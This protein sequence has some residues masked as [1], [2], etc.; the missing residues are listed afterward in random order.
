MK[1]LVAYYSRYGNTAHLAN[2]LSDTL[3]KSGKADIVQIEYLNRNPNILKRIFYR[4]LPVF[5][6][7]APVQEDLKGYDRLFVCIPVWGGRP[8][9]PITKYLLLTKNTIGK[10]AICFYVYGFKKSALVCSD[11]VERMLKKRGFS[12]IQ[13]IFVHWDN[14]GNEV[15]LSKAI[16]ESLASS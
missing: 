8:S 12:S 1:D 6:E 15:F 3:S 10:K 16:S 9:A 13:N 5:V 4:L 2:Y 14:V 11:Y 7:I